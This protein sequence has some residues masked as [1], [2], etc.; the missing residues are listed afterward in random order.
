MIFYWGFIY[1]FFVLGVGGIFLGLAL[2]LGRRARTVGWE[3]LSA[4]ECGFQP[5]CNV[6]IPFSLQFYLVAIIFLLFDIEL[7]LILPYLSDSE[8]Y[9]TVFIFLFFLVLLLGLIHESNE[10]SFEWR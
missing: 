9:G 7:V 8:S 3:T 6:R 4:Y 2:T 5:M 10:G 1:F